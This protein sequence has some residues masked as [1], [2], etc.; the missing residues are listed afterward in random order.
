MYLVRPQKQ[1]FLI[2]IARFLQFTGCHMTL[3]PPS[4]SEATDEGFF[5]EL[6]ERQ[7]EFLA[8]VTSRL[9]DVPLVHIHGCH[10]AHLREA[11]RVER[12]G[13]GLLPMETATAV[14]CIDGTEGTGGGGC[15]RS[16]WRGECAIFDEDAVF[17]TNDL[18]DQ[19]AVLVWIDHTFGFDFL[20]GCWREVIMHLFVS[21][22][23]QTHLFYRDGSTCIAF[24]TT[25]AVALFQVAAKEDL[26]EVEGNQG[27]EYLNHGT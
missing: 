27:V 13:N 25:K 3:V 19:F 2:Q 18:C 4:L 6:I 1:R 14:G 24:H 26:E 22:F 12:T 5:Q 11:H 17:A 7:L 15:L 21:F 9:A 8:Q 23:E 10:V 16:I 20:P